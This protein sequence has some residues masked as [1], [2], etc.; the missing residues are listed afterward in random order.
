MVVDSINDFVL[1]LQNILN[2]DLSFIFGKM[3]VIFNFPEIRGIIATG[4]W[5]PFL[6]DIDNQCKPRSEAAECGV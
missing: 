6:R 2:P 3:Q 4:H 1:T 5:R